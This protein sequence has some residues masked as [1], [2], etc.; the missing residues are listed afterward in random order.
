[1][2]IN[3]YYSQQTNF[4]PIITTPCSNL[5]LRID[6]PG[7]SNRLFLSNFNYQQ[8]WI[9]PI[10]KT[11]PVGGTTFPPMALARSTGVVTGAPLKGG[12]RHQ[13]VSPFYISHDIGGNLLAYAYPDEK[14]P[15]SPNSTE[16]S[17]GGVL[18]RP[19]ASCRCAASAARG[20]WCCGRRPP[21]VLRWPNFAWTSGK[22]KENHGKMVISAEYHG[23]IIKFIAVLTIG[24][25]WF[26]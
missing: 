13:G 10:V 22:P 17:Q 23:N 12:R 21:P 14:F 6:C 2:V 19:P 18:P 24:K 25:W 20:V 4:V 7:S 16:A 9:S 1:M 15:A 3:D 11:E 26:N 8:T 5:V